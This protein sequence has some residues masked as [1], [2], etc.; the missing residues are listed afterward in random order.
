MRKVRFLWLVPVLFVS[1]GLWAQDTVYKL[2]VDVPMVTLE[3]FVKDA[4]ERPVISLTPT[5]FEIY[6]DGERQEIRYFGAAETPRSVLLAFDVTGVLDKQAPFMVQ[7][8]NVFLANLREQDRIAFGIIGPEFEM[9]MPFRKMEKGKPVGLKVPKERIGS[10][11]YDSLDM[12]ARRFTKEEGR[13][14]IIVLTDGRETQLFNETQRLGFV[15]A[16]SDDSHFKKYLNEARKR[17]IPYYFIA[18]DT[19][20]QYITGT[21]ME[22]AYF[23]RPEGYM[24]SA[25]YGNGQRR[26]RIAEEFL[27]G[28]RARMEKLAEATGGLVI[29]PRSI[30]HVVALYTQISAELGYSYSLGYL[31]KSANDGQTHKIEVRLKDKNLKVSQSRNSYG[32]PELKTTK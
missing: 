9:L 28:V 10:N 17:G 21:D 4:T 15:P 29:Y 8:V 18:L 3:A 23:K 27:E 14:A 1:I 32:G 5:D 26:P 11:L 25:Q 24:R 7:G 20:P 22:Y 16:I 30:D 2:K 6:E 19:D 13:K 12:G 31:P